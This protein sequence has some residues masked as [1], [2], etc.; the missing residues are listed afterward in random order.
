[1]QLLHNGTANKETLPVILQ[2]SILLPIHSGQAYIA[3]WREQIMQ[4]KKKEQKVSDS[5]LT[6]GPGC[7]GRGEAV[8]Q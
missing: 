7:A 5:R 3:Y 2:I 4:E 1:M 8:L 6:G